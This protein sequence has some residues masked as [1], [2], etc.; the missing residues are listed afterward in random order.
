LNDDNILI[1]A[2]D[3][4][5]ETSTPPSPT[6]EKATTNDESWLSGRQNA[7]AENF[8]EKHKT[9][10]QDFE[11]IEHEKIACFEQFHALEHEIAARRQWLEN[12][13]KDIAG[14][15]DVD[16]AADL[17][18]NMQMTGR[19]LLEIAQNPVFVGVALIQ[20]HGKKILQ[21]AEADAAILQN[22]FDT[23]K[24]EKRELL[25]ELELV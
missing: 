3:G 22:K 4:A 17:F 11:R 1:M 15:Q 5:T 10:F 13:Q 8:L 19:P 16:L 25:K 7:F 20:K 6:P 12:L 18:K 9:E 24:S 23:F 2:D 21:L 14:Y